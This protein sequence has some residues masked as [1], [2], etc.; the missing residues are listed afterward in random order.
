MGY[1][2]CIEN[3]INGKKY[4]GQTVD[5]NKRIQI[6]YLELIKNQ[7]HSS[8][9]Q[10]AW[11]KYNWQFKN[12][13]IEEIDNSLMN[14]REKYWISYYNTYNEGYN[15]TLG[16]DSCG[17]EKNSKVVYCYDKE[18][19]YLNLFFP[20][21]R[22]TSRELEIDQSLVYKICN[23]TA[24][25]QT[26]TSKKDNN[27][28]RFSY[29]LLEKLPPLKS[30][31]NTKKVIQ[32]DLDGNFIR[33]WDSISDAAEAVLGSRKRRGSINNVLAG[34]RKTTGGYKW[35]YKI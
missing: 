8:K 28:Y 5:Y 20:S 13:I 24:G 19:N 26:A 21:T 25:K 1:I 34:R 3:L 7:H 15:E 22:E 2:Y 14:E 16:G 30:N 27:V 10:R 29:E 11:N 32:L 17:H 18:G 4:I 31:R 33:E 35:Q 23:N 6:H 9:L 12:Y